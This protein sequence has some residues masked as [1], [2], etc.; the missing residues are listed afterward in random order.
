MFAKSVVLENVTNTCPCIKQYSRRSF[1]KFSE[2]MNVI[3]L[4]SSLLQTPH[5]SET[6]DPRCAVQVIDFH[7]EYY[8]VVTELT[9]VHSPFLCQ[10]ATTKHYVVMLSSMYRAPLTYRFLRYT[11]QEVSQW[12]FSW[13]CKCDFREHIC[14]WEYLACSPVS[15]GCSFFAFYGWWASKH[16]CSTWYVRH[17][18]RAQFPK[19]HDSRRKICALYK[20]IINHCKC[21]Q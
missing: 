7:E 3:Q 4:C 17:N 8:R 10:L 20:P 2:I 1:P 19:P 12:L 13:R 11:L 16:S 14:N 5:K 9:Q 21:S 6:A 18:N 15:W